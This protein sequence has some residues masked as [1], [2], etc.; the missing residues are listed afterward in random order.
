M[1]AIG[2]V[3]FAPLAA[4]EALAVGIARDAGSDA[5][6][7]AVGTYLAVSLLMFGSALCAGLVDVV[8]GQ[9]FGEHDVTVR[10]ALR[11]LPYGHLIGVDVAQSLVV[12]TASLLGLVPGVIGFTFICLAGAIVMVDRVP[13]WTALRGSIELTRHRFGLTFVVV[14]LPVAVEHQI[15]HALGVYFELR[16]VVLWAIHAAAAVAVLVPVVVI[17]ITLTRL[18][19]RELR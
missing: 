8:V 6:A 15:L 11:T 3:L 5:R 10:R 19:R 9:E 1:A 18:L 14:T 16:F 12:G 13:G 17:E 2:L 4:L 7:F